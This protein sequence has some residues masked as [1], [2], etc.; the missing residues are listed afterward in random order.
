MKKT[1]LTALVLALA[2]FAVFAEDVPAWIDN[3]NGTAVNSKTG[4]VTI[5]GLDG[6][7]GTADDNRLVNP[8]GKTLV[9]DVKAD[10]VDGIP[11]IV[12]TEKTMVLPGADGL[13]GTTDDVIMF[14]SY[15]QSADLAD[16]PEP[17]AWH[18]LSIS[19]G[20]A[21]I[22]SEK[23]LS[24]VQ[25]NLRDTD[26]N[27]WA[28]SNMRSWLN[29]RGGENLVGDTTGFYDAAFNLA[30]KARIV[31]TLV[32]MSSNTKYDAYNTLK[33]SDWWE[34]YSTHGKDT[35]DCVFALSAEEVFEY[36][37]P[38]KV[39]TFEELGHAP[40]YYTN[41]M[42]NGTDFAV[43]CGLKTNTGGNGASYIGYAD[44]WTRSPGVVTD[45]FSCGT[46]L[47][48]VGS[49]NSGRPVT[50]SYGARPAATIIL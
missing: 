49:L 4:V 10:F 41:G 5:T 11:V 38:S 50:R 35:V 36:F 8:A 6:I 21:L 26:G 44:S 25:Y 47:G 46:F 40:T 17:I 48:S 14:G 13:I 9:K 30:E 15:Q 2:L 31:P 16:G 23:I 28:E 39:A 3:G 12:L 22:V 43:A 20:K 32:K 42:A 7:P 1:F 37:G 18:I 34:V 45:E 33:S 24:P 29:S 27:E 19:K